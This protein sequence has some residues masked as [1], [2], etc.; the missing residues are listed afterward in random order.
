MLTSDMK[1]GKHNLPCSHK[2]FKH[3]SCTQTQDTGFGVSGTNFVL[4]ILT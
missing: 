2:N 1:T 3:N 4:W